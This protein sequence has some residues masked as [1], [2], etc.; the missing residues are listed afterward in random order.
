VL[1]GLR[2]VGRENL[3]LI[4]NNS[5]TDQVAAYTGAVRRVPPRAG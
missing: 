4:I 2:V 1:S 5:P 3:F